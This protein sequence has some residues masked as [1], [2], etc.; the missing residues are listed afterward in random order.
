MSSQRWPH[1][2]YQKI[3]EL[4]QKATMKLLD[5]SRFYGEVVLRLNR[6]YDDTVGGTMG[7]SW[8]APFWELRINPILF[9]E[10]YHS[11]ADVK[12]ALT[13]QVLHMVWEHPIRYAD[14]IAENAAEAKMVGLATD[15]SVNQY[16]RGGFPG[17]HTLAEVEEM[18]E[19]DLPTYADSSTYYNLL[20]PLMDTI[21]NEGASSQLPGDDHKGWSTGAEAGEEAEAALR[22]VVADANHDA[23]VA[24]RGNMAGE[25]E[26]Q[27]EQLLAPRRNWRG[28]L[29]KAMSNVPAG[30]QDSRARFNRRQ[31][32]R[33]ELPGQVD[34][35]QTKIAVFIDNSASISDDTASR[36]IAEVAQMQKQLAA[37]VD[38]F[39]FDTEVHAIDKNWIADGRRRAGG[40]TRFATIFETLQS[41]RYQPQST[42]VVIFTDGDGEQ[43][44]PANRYRRLVWVLP[45]DATLS[46]LQPV[47]Q[48]VTLTKW[49]VD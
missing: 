18:I 25:V 17:A 5:E 19:L 4:I 20:H 32:Y 30:K 46:V 24:G 29:R 42:V 37:A 11:V 49:E 39:A 41:E 27:I 28:L 45:T 47:G 3:D 9:E 16:I 31:P 7:L 12:G 36:F 15:L 13:H 2:T 33:M 38:F 22:N 14:K 48:V 43:E 44:L 23:L 35:T 8:Q 10:V 34:A 1:M 6:V 40:G 21:D 26:R